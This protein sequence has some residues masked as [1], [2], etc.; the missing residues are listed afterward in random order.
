MKTAI[1][2]I[3]CLA[4]AQGNRA[5]SGKNQG[6]IRLYK[7]VGILI[8]DGMITSIFHGGLTADCDNIID[9]EHRLVT[10]GL[11][12]AHTHLVFGGWRENELALKLHGV[13]YLDILRQ[14]GGILSTVNA[15]RNATE[16]ELYDK[17]KDAL[18]EMLSLGTTTCEA[19]SGYGLS[20]DS[21]MKQLRVV[22]RLNED[23]PVELVSTFM[24]AHAVPP[25]YKQN[26]AGYIS[27]IVNEMLPEA[28]SAELAEFCDVF[29]ESEV[30]DADESR[31]ILT[32]AQKLGMK[33]KIH[34]DEINAIG[35]TELA[36]EIN[37]ISAEHL[38]AC[39]ESGIS[40]M[41]KGGVIACCLPCTSFYLGKGFAP[42]RQMIDAGVPV[43]VATD[44]N[45]GSTPNLSLQLAMNMGCYKYRMT[46]EEVLT[47]VTLNAAAAI[48][49][50]DKVGT[51]EVGKQADLLIWDSDN[52]NRIFYRYGH[53]QVMTVIKKGIIAAQK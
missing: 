4:T 33:A 6:D 45:P 31:E 12:D 43:A 47:A 53:N 5:K 37:A 16:Q 40:A 10:P 14:G 18:S 25:E 23:Q 30:F 9:A 27:L 22:K 36:G 26:R 48:D 32:A 11:V 19:K 15:T 1:I 51:A 20:L 35:G 8:E 7:D 28:I 2:N 3:G 21:E 49:R 42:A 39:T 44:F 46:P 29:C 38:I 24:A 50:A 34:A 13:E 52:L 41:A 17:T